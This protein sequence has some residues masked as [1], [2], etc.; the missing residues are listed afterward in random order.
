MVNGP[1]GSLCMDADRWERIDWRA[2]EEQVRR[3]RSRIFKAV[4]EG[5]RP[6]A[7]NLQRT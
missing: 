4:Q 7:R 6:K 5:D 3:M 1:E 2:Q